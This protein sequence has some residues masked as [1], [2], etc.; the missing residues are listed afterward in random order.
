MSY[1]RPYNHRLLVP[2]ENMAS[3]LRE[4]ELQLRRAQSDRL[5][6]AGSMHEQCRLPEQLL[7]RDWFQDID[8]CVKT[9]RFDEVVVETGACGILPIMRLSVSGHR[10]D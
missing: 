6:L 1:P 7:S 10:N 5:G 3:L 9:Y 4:R 2:A 8:D